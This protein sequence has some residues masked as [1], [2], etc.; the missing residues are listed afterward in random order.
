[1]SEFSFYSFYGAWDSPKERRGR[2][3]LEAWLEKWHKDRRIILIEHPTYDFQPISL[4]TV[5]AVSSDAVR[6]LSIG[7]T[8][9]LVDSGGEQRTGQVCRFMDLVEDSRA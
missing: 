7:R 6:E 9:V 3:S 1:M 2:M 8:V 4:Q 5:E